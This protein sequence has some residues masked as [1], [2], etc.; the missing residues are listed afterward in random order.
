MALTRALAVITAVML[1]WSMA[2]LAQPAPDDP[3]PLPEPEP[4]PD[5]AVPPGDPVPPDED[6]GGTNSPEVLGPIVE[7]PV[8]WTE[9]DIEPAT[10]GGKLLESEATVRAMLAPDMK[11]R[12]ALTPSAREDLVALCARLGYQLV[13]IEI[14]KPGNGVVRAVLYL[15]PRLVVRRVRVDVDQLSRLFVQDEIL[16]RV[17][18]RV[19]EVLEV[20]DDARAS[21]L[22]DEAERLREFLQD[23][24][25]FEAR[26]SIDVARSGVYGANLTINAALGKDYQVGKITIKNENK[27]AVSGE[28]IRRMFNHCQLQAF[29]KCW[30]RKRFS[31]SQHQADIQRLTEL[32]QKRGYPAVRV[33]TD[34]NSRTSFDRTTK[35]VDFT[36][37]VDERRRLAVEFEGNDAR[38]FSDDTLAAQLTFDDASSADDFEVS[39]S[40]TAIQRYYQQRGWFDAAVTWERERVRLEDGRAGERSID[41][42]RYRIDAGQQRQLRGVEIVGASEIPER[43]LRAVLVTQP[44]PTSFR[45][46]G[47]NT[48]TTAE[49]LRADADRL[50]GLYR[51]RGYQ[52]ATVEIHAAP[53]TQGLGD[54]AVTAAILAAERGTRELY[55]R[56]TIVEGSRTVIEGVE[57][58]FEG[59]HLASKSQVLEQLAIKSGG[60][61]ILADVKAAGTKLQDYYW[62]IG[63]P[64]ARVTLEVVAGSDEH[65]VQIS[66]KVEER[67][68]LRI[69]KVVVRGNF[70]TK[71]WVVLQELGFRE[72][73]LLT[74]DL[75]TKGLRRLRTTGLFSAVTVELVNFEENR[76]DTVNVVVRVEERNDVKVYV[77]FEAGYS[78]QK[79]GYVKAAPVLPNM[80][81]TGITFNSGL[82][83]GF[84]FKAVEGTFRFPRWV[85][86]KYIKVSPDVEASAYWR[87]Q[88]TERFGALTTFGGA[89]AASRVWQRAG[90]EGKS[91]RSIAAT[92]RYDFRRRSRQEDAVR[93]AGNNGNVSRS[94]VFNNIG[95]IGLHL[96]WDQRVD[97]RG[98]LNPL[99]PHKGFKLETGVSL[100]SR[101]LLSQDTFVKVSGVGQWIRQLS[102]RTQLRLEGRFDQGF[103]LGRAVLLP[104]VE[105]FFAGGDDT[106]RGF[107]EDR[108]ATEVVEEP[109]PPFG[110]ITQITVLPAGGN[111]RILGSIDAQVRLWKMWS[112]PVA[113]A[114]FVDAGVIT[115]AY[116]GLTVD[117]IR[118]SAGVALFRLLTPFGGLSLEWAVPLRPRPVDPPLGRLHFLVALR[119]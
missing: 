111:I 11:T 102:G 43:E 45:L 103:P 32:Y 78:D 74:S 9:W 21:Q 76:E 63:R 73:A 24:G 38:L 104:E 18:L 116:S 26:V 92:F 23:E 15:E 113:S 22:R 1:S 55:V 2:A 88:D 86:R 28:E 30:L 96:S 51:A 112:L 6:L 8:L 54:A 31:R 72:G 53:S 90:G 16:R 34:Y 5:D 7:P 100:A 12:Q 75:Y 57:V 61:Y 114:L 29:G 98:N 91:A 10:K 14:E 66:Y 46:L 109:V 41:Q 4:E 50:V 82:T 62:K 69:G 47:G 79:S 95:A 106:V 101:L 44:A 65:H 94:T 36:V 48:A 42:I 119:Y 118:P 117:D 60:P 107:D 89:L 19:G 64:R 3:A 99:S 77:D 49:Q 17:R 80:W 85:T 83:W 59:P 35:K 93:V 27:L 25:F 97:Q 81:G 37:R 105:R 56:F 115:N 87:L 52:Q 108:L 68:E 20:E 70:R 58:I 71:R 33:Q 13:R 40:A 39:A 84:D 67:Q 110:G